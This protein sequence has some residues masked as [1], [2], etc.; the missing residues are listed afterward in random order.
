MQV[1]NHGTDPWPKGQK[2]V[3][4]VLTD[5]PS[6]PDASCSLSLE[7]GPLVTDTVVTRSREGRHLREQVVW[8]DTC[9]VETL[10]QAAVWPLPTKRQGQLRKNPVSSRQS[11]ACPLQH[12]RVARVE[13]VSVWCILSRYYYEYQRGFPGFV[14]L[15]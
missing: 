10:S 6:T 1:F 2:S 5:Q 13:D 3:P 12:L 14:H 9:S 15:F 11:P 7:A 8:K 4:C